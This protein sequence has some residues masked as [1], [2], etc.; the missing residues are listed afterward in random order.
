MSSALIFIPRHILFFH[1]PM[2]LRVVGN[3]DM[4]RMRGG[5]G[6]RPNKRLLRVVHTTINDAW[7]F[8]FTLE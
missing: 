7:V 2:R 6:R 5:A 4:S 1:N 8:L 3:G